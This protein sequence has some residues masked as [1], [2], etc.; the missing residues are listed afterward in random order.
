M[1]DIP[2]CRG[3]RLCALVSACGSRAHS[4]VPLQT[5]DR[6]LPQRDSESRSRILGVAGEPSS[7]F[8]FGLRICVVLPR[9][10]GYPIFLMSRPPR[11][12]RIASIIWAI[13]IGA[14]V[15]FVGA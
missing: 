9:T 2:L 1:R 4:R 14:L 3:T 10:A 5:M 13:V 12:V 11:G 7:A 6:L 15:L 8:H